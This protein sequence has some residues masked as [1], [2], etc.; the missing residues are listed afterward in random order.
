[1]Y[2]HLQLSSKLGREDV[3][4]NA[5][6]GVSIFFHGILDLLLTDS[7][8]VVAGARLECTVERNGTRILGCVNESR[9]R[10]HLVSEIHASL[11]EFLQ[12]GGV[13]VVLV[14]PAAV[15]GNATKVPLAHDLTRDSL[16]AIA[17]AKGTVA[18]SSVGG[19]NWTD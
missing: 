15:E 19:L 18:L 10:L 2:M 12:I 11:L 3:A 9:M 6:I 17:K 5:F 13:E 4:G 7:I 16:I 14:V 8:K 1:M